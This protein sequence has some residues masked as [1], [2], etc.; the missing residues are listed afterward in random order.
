LDGR[1]RLAR[2]RLSKIPLT[3]RPVSLSTPAVYLRTNSGKD[4][5]TNLIQCFRFYIPGEIH[6]L[7]KV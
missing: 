2:D 7:W 5:I 6:A 4:T 3:L 1:G